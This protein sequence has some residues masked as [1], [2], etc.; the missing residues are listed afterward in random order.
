MHAVQDNARDVA[1][2][3]SV[4][5]A[6]GKLRALARRMQQ[7]RLHARPAPPGKPCCVAVVF[8][9]AALCSRAAPR[10]ARAQPMSVAARHL[11]RGLVCLYFLNL[12]RAARANARFDECT[13]AHLR[14]FS[15]SSLL[16]HAPA[17]HCPAPCQCWEN[18]GLYHY[19]K[20][21]FESSP[22][23]ARAGSGSSAPS[24][25][26]GSLLI[27]APSAL[28]CALGV[29]TRWAAGILTL[30]MIKED[31]ELI[32][33]GVLGL[34]LN[35]VRPNELMVKK[36]SMFGCIAL[37]F[38]GA[39]G[40]DAAARGGVAGMLTDDAAPT[41][42]SRRKSAVLLAGRLMMAAL[43]LYVGT[44]QLARI[45]RRSEL[46][47]HRVDPTD[48]HD[49]NWLILELI[50]SIPFAFGYKTRPVTLSL[51]A[52]LACEALSAWRF[53]RF[54]A[55]A[56]RGAWALGKYIHARSHFVTN[57]SVA[58]GLLLL[59][60]RAL[61]PCACACACALLCVLRRRMSGRAER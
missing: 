46:W 51:A 5:E 24:Y 33:R 4:G 43:F 44:G 6:S 41:L 29:R 59:T 7:V 2:S 23:N 28:A 19:Y 35:G 52:T 8:V 40:K 22:R 13:L 12:A 15:L 49:N 50:L 16:S 36:L 37:V 27:I 54:R 21:Q 20:T 30:D 56:A 34:V 17:P 58:G 18:V 1:N 11:G 42:A 61:C 45:S 48:G 57:L 55:D 53:W 47:S 25:P 9:C 38:V 14:F 26:Y 31:T 10:R 39:G 32:Y 3:R 60:V